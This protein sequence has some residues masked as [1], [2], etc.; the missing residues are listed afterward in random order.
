MAM[1]AVKQYAHEISDVTFLWCVHSKCGKDAAFVT[2]CVASTWSWSAMLL[3]AFPQNESAGS[4]AL[5]AVV[6]GLVQE[7][8]N[9]STGWQY[10]YL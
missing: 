6:S 2:P 3:P 5:G 8:D 10:W 7:M 4:V 9:S 1:K